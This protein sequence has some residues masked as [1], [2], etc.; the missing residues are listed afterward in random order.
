MTTPR[1]LICIIDDEERIRGLLLE[2][3]DDYEEFE[4]MGAGSG[5]EGLEM[6]TR[7]PA[8]LCIVD[9][10]LPGMSGEMFIVAASKKALCGKYL[11]HS[12]SM[13]L[14]LSEELKTLGLTE[15]DV[16]LKPATIDHIVVR[17]RQLLGME[18]R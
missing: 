18:A 8:D 16:F 3:L 4:L 12:G 1:P 5:E 13:D 10:R 17:I 2:A 9:M 7:T 11:L 15:Q 14:D 6:L